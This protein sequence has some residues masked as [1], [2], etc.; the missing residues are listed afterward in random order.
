MLSLRKPAGLPKPLH[1]ISNTTVCGI[2]T[3]IVFCASFCRIL[4]TWDIL[5]SCQCPVLLNMTF[6]LLALFPAR[7]IWTKCCSKTAMA[8]FS[9]FLSYAEQ[10]FHYYGN[11][12]VVRGLG[13]QITFGNYFFISSKR[14]LLLILIYIYIC[15]GG[16][17]Y[18]L[19]TEPLYIHA[20]KRKK[21]KQTLQETHIPCCQR[22]LCHTQKQGYVHFPG[23]WHKLGFR[24]GLQKL[25]LR[26]KARHL[27]KQACLSDQDTSL[28]CSD[29]PFGFLID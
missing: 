16:H 17:R 26:I 18:S 23:S 3:K 13:W 5:W 10:R 11:Y 12:P 27:K 6:F 28:S 14:E 24:A 1:A 20:W 21:K 29:T 4:P 2:Q 19:I 8:W 9:Y 25:I 15:S 22:D 7:G